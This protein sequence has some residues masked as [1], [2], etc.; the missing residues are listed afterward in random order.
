LPFWAAPAKR[1]A[2]WLHDIGYTPDL[3]LTGLH[4]L[5]GARYL[6]DPQHADAMLCRLVAHHS[7]AIVEADERGHADVLSLEFEPAPHALS[8]VLT[9]CDMTTS[10][11][12]KLVPV[13]SDSLRY[14]TGTAPATWSAGQSGMPRR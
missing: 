6:R 10:P 7:Y 14:T 3:A 5:D 13:E 4:A 1:D 8:R 9:C 11:D 12:G 2:A